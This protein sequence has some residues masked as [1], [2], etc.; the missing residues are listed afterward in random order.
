ML[1]I[2]QGAD[3]A[4]LQQEHHLSNAL[5]QHLRRKLSAL[6][7][8]LEPD[9]SLAEFSLLHHGFIGVLEPGDRT[10]STI[11]LPESL[12]HIMPEW[13]SKLEISGELYYVL[14]IMSDND[15][16]IQIYL[17]EPLLWESLTMWLSQQ[18]LEEEEEEED[19]WDEVAS[20]AQPF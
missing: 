10:L 6:Q 20:D 19:E 9:T 17:P 2:K 18:P 13:V 1:I 15:C 5:T 8:A 11:G 16:V 4:R 7:Q 12:A 14:Y 3:I